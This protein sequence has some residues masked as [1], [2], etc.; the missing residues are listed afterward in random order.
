MTLT[1]LD[2]LLVFLA[3]HK[4]QSGY[5]IRQLFQATPLGVFSDSPGSIYPSLARLEA[6]RLLASTGEAS[7]R[8][9]RTYRRTA[10]GSKALTAWLAMPI[11]D[12]AK[13]KQG[14][15]ELRFVMIAESLSWAKALQFLAAAE[16]LYKAKLKELDAFMAGPGAQMTRASRAA[17]ELGMRT[18]R[19][20]IQW[21]R[22]MQKQAR[23]T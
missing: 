12:E 21:C 11:V 1:L 22:E 6:R 15:M 7:G 23:G 2:A 4:G 5:D 10:E 13:L 8:R 3:G 17:V 14:E 9:R 20:R 19:L 16:A 18:C